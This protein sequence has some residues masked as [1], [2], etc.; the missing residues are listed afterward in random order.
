MEELLRTECRGQP[1]EADVDGPV[2]VPD[3][4]EALRRGDD[5]VVGHE[6]PRPADRDLGIRV[7]ERDPFGAFEEQEVAESVLPERHER[8][9]HAGREVLRRRREVRPAEVRRRA[10]R[11]QQ[12]LDERE[13][14]HLLLRDG[15]D[16]RAPAVHRL[17]LL[18]GEALIGAL[19]HRE[20][21]EEVLAEDR[22]LELGGLAEQVDELLAVLDDD[23][24]LGLGGD[25]ADRGAHANGLGQPP[26]ERRYEFS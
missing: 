2:E 6:R 22:V 23:R 19:L 10:D 9:L 3:R 11:R 13:V 8:D 12:V 24:R 25:V 4:R 26:S 16:R 1:G 17:E 20:G 7:V 18:G 14:Q 15:E 5:V 21:R